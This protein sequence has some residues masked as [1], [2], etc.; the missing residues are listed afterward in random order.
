MHPAKLAVDPCSALSSLKHCE[1]AVVNRRASSEGEGGMMR[2]EQSLLNTLDIQ[3]V[4]ECIP[5]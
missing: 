3:R 4:H 1:S 5:L 2:S